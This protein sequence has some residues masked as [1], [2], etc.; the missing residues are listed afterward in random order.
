[1][2]KGLEDV[3]EHTAE[4]IPARARSFLGGDWLGHPLHPALTDLPIG[5]WTS[6]FV[7]DFLGGRRA[8]V[9][10][11]FVGLGVLTAVPTIAS[12]VVEWS[13]LE[14]E[15]KRE[16]G[17]LHMVANV[18]ATL[19]YTWSFFARVRGRR[20]RGIALGLLGATAAT[21]GGYLGG[22]LVFGENDAK[23]EDPVATPEP[24]RP[25]PVRSD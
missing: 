23:A 7:L 9:A 6:A 8:R 16:T 12:G 10:T 25:R 24:L 2:L 14:D 17:I 18:V 3:L 5:F 4:A 15:K 19:L 20:G 13:T 21:I 1:M 22:R 11:G